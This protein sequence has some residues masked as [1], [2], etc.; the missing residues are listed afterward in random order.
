MCRFYTLVLS[1]MA[2]LGFALSAGATEVDVIYDLAPSS[3]SYAGQSAGPDAP[4][5]QMTIRYQSGPSGTILSGPA[6][7]ISGGLNQVLDIGSGVDH[8]SGILAID[9]T[10]PT[11]GSL[12][13]TGLVGFG[14][15]AQVSGS[16]HCGFWCSLVGGTKT[17]SYFVVAGA[18]IDVFFGT[19]VVPGAGSGHSIA[20]TPDKSAGSLPVGTGIPVSMALVGQ[21]V[22]RQVVVQAPALGP[23]AVSL[24]SVLMLGGLTW[25]RRTR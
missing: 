3:V 23:W 7:L 16:F 18:S 9:L 8:D 22:S 2:V 6:R 10:G 19:G 4:V 14:I 17:N 5:G 25:W 21:E 20:I 15:H 1:V 24:T 12:G 13:A 11:S